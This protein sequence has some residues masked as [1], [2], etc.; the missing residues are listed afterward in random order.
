MPGTSVTNILTRQD[1]YM[2][3]GT[4]AVS[5]LFKL[6]YGEEI[7]LIKPIEKTPASNVYFKTKHVLVVT[8]LVDNHYDNR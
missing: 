4:D 6:L 7:E 1:F 3:K 5:I 8:C 2:S